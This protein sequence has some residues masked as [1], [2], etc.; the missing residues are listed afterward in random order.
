MG[1]K[2]DPG[3]SISSPEVTVSP[4]TQTV[5]ENQTA[6]FNCS[7]RGSPRPT[8]TWSKVNG[9]LVAKHLVTDQNGGLKITKSIFNDSGDYMCTAVNVLGRDEKTAKLIVEGK[10]E[11]FL[12]CYFHYYCC[13]SHLV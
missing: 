8:V 1:F 12:I 9:S 6:T 7:V 2:G 11:L 3:E 5:T 4:A 13:C 10:N